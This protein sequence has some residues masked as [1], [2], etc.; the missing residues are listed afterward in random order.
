ML[1][2]HLT[3]FERGKIELLVRS[4]WSRRRIADEMK[5][6]PSTISREVKRSSDRRGRYQALTAQLAYQARRTRCV[7][8]RKLEQYPRLRAYVCEK[9]REQWS[10]DEIACTLRLDFPRDRSMRISHETIYTFVYAD[11][12]QNGTLYAHL[13]QSHRKRRRRQ[14]TY[15]KRGLFPGR[16]GIEQRPKIVDTRRR[17]GDWE[18]DL[19]HGRQGAPAILTLVE[20]KHGYLL[21]HKVDNKRAYTVGRAFLKAFRC[22]PDQ[23]LKTIT[24]DNG[25]EFADFKTIE[26]D[27]ETNIYFADPY[28]AWQRGTNENTNGLL[29]QYIPKKADLH[30]FTQSDLNHIVEKLNNRPRKRL[31]YRTPAQ[32]FQKATG[33]LQL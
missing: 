9:I 23:L 22:V 32:L 21:A 33:A 13:R 25:N 19:V 30:A 10:P 18:G 7:K 29:R 14:N 17:V 3:P 31:K 28:C 11:K 20:R 6:N 27:L 12:R 4:G 16:V 26:K 15:T 5:R 24:L 2:T 8:P 1:Y